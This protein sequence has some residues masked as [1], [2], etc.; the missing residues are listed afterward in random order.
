MLHSQVVRV[1]QVGLVGHVVQK[2]HLHQKVHE[3]PVRDQNITYT[4][5]W[6][7]SRLPMFL[8][9]TVTNFNY[10]FLTSNIVFKRENS[11]Q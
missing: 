10:T 1:V 7:L 11:F 9:V 8:A 3:V 6:L 2:V 5:K 4:S